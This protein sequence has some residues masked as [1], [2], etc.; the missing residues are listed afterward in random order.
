VPR[1][2][3]EKTGKESLAERWILHKYTTAVKE[4]NQALENREFQ[5]ATLIV[6]QYWY[7]QLCDVYIVSSGVSLTVDDCLHAY[8][9]DRKTPRQS[10]KM[11]PNMKSGP[12]R[13]RCI[14]LSK[15][16]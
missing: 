10:F 15:A 16:H 12:L 7:N 1:E 11:E 6:Y 2:S 14:P 13:I 5:Q 9:N 8:R 3:S 4:I